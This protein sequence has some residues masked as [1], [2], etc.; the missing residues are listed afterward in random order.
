[1]IMANSM[2]HANNGYNVKNDR[3]ICIIYNKQQ[4]LK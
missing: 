1:M 4:E 3:K 2:Q